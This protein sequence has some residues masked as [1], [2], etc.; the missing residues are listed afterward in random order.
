MS[1]S[2]NLVIA[3]ILII[4]T[5]FL[6]STSFAT[7]SDDNQ[8]TLPLFNNGI[9][10]DI[11]NFTYSK[12][13]DGIYNITTQT[14]T[15]YFGFGLTANNNGVPVQYITSDFNWEHSKTDIVNGFNITSK[16]SNNAW[17]TNFTFTNESTKIT[18]SITNIGPRLTDTKFYYIFSVNIGDNISYRDRNYQVKEE[19]DIHL[20]NDNLNLNTVATEI[21]KNNDFYFD[22]SDII[23]DGFNVTDIHLTN[24]SNLGLGTGKTIAMGFTKNNGIFPNGTTVI[25]DPKI[26][27]K[28]SYKSVQSNN[29][30]FSGN[31][32]SDVVF[33]IKSE[34]KSK[35][36]HMLPI[37]KSNHADDVSFRVKT[38]IFNEIPT[39]QENTYVVRQ[40]DDDGKVP[41]KS[42]ITI[43]PDSEYTEFQGGFSETVVGGITAKFTKTCTGMLNGDSC[44]FDSVNST[45]VEINIT[46]TRLNYIENAITNGNATQIKLLISNSSGTNTNTSVYFNGKTYNNFSDVVSA[47]GS[48]QQY[49]HFYNNL[50]GIIYINRTE[51]G[52]VK[53][54]YNKEGETYN[55]T[56]GGTNTYQPNGFFPFDS[57]ID[58]TN[59]FTSASQASYTVIGGELRMAEIDSTA[60]YILLKNTHNNSIFSVRVRNTH[61]NGAPYMFFHPTT[62]WTANDGM[63]YENVSPKSQV[64]VGGSNTVNDSFAQD[65]SGIY[66]FMLTIPLTGN[67]TSAIYLPTGSLS[68][69][70]TG[71]PTSRTGYLSLFEWQ[72]S[73][74][75]VDDITIRNSDTASWNTWSA[76]KNVSANFTAGTHTS[77][78]YNVTD[79]GFNETIA[80]Q[81][82][83]NVTYN[84]NGYGTAT[85]EVIVYTIDDIIQLTNET[86]NGSIFGNSTYTPA[87]YL[88]DVNITIKKPTTT[89]DNEGTSTLITNDTNATLT[90]EN[91]TQWNITS[92]AVNTSIELYYNVSKSINHNPT[93]SVSNQGFTSSQNILVVVTSS[94]TDGSSQLTCSATLD[95]TTINTCTSPIDF[96]TKSSGDYTFYW[97]GTDNNGTLS[98]TGTPFNETA[99]I[100]ITQVVISPFSLR[101]GLFALQNYTIPSNGTIL[102]NKNHSILSNSI[103]I[104]FDNITGSVWN[105][106]KNSLQYSFEIGT[107]IGIQFQFNGKYNNSEYQNNTKNNISTYLSDLT[108]DPYESTLQWIEFDL[109]NESESLSDM[110]NFSNAMAINISEVTNNKFPIYTLQELSSLDNTYIIG[111]STDAMNFIDSSTL[112][113]FLDNQSQQL[114]TSTKKSV[115]Y[116]GVAQNDTILNAISSYKTNIFNRMRGDIISGFSQP[117]EYYSVYIDNSSGGYDIILFNNQSTIQNRTLPSMTG[118]Y[119]DTTNDIIKTYANTTLGFNVSANSFIYIMNENVSKLVLNNSNA[120]DVYGQSTIYS[121]TFLYNGTEATDGIAPPDSWAFAGDNE[122]LKIELFDPTYQKSG[123]MIHYEWINA[124]RVSDYS[125]YDYVIVADKNPSE[126]SDTINSS[127]IYGYVAVSDYVNT[128]Q[129][130]SDKINETEWW[131]DRGHNLFIDGID[132][133]VGGTNFSNRFKAIVDHVRITDNKETICNTY[134]AYQEFATYCNAVMKESAFSRWDGTVNNPVYSYEDMDLEKQR[135][136]YYNS[137]NIPVILM[138]FGAID[139]YEKQDFTFKAGAVVYGYDGNNSYKYGQPN[140]QSQAEIYVSDLGTMLESSYTETSPTD[141]NRLYSKGRVHINPVNHTA[142][143]DDSKTINYIKLEAF[144]YSGTYA[145]P[146]GIQVMMQ[147]PNGSGTITD[148]YCNCSV[149]NWKWR[150]VSIPISE[151]K[152]HGHYWTYFSNRGTGQ[153]NFMAHDNTQGSGDG[154]HSYWE[155][156]ASAN[157][158]T[159]GNESNFTW[160]A[161]PRDQNWMIRLNI[162]YTSTLKID[163]INNSYITQSQSRDATG[164]TTLNL[165]TTKDYLVNIYT[166]TTRYITTT[167]SQVF[168]K[169]FGGEWTVGNIPS[170]NTT[171]INATSISWTETTVDGKTFGI[172]MNYIS[173]NNW[174]IRI[175]LPDSTSEA[176]IM[177]NV[178]PSI[179]NASNKTAIEG[180]T[181][182]IDIDGTDLNSDTLSYSINRTDLFSDFSTSTGQGNWTTTASTEG[183]YIVDAGVS[184]GIGNTNTTFTITIS[185]GIPQNLASVNN[186]DHAHLSWDAVS[187]ASHYNISSLQHFIYYNSTGATIDGLRDSQYNATAIELMVDTPNPI[188]PGSSDDFFLFYNDTHI[189]MY[190][191]GT[192]NDNIPNDDYAE[193]YL[194]L[195]ANGLTT[196]DYAYKVSE[197]SSLTRLK[198]SGSAWLTNPGSS[199]NSTATGSSTNNLTFEIEIPLSELS[200]SNNSNIKLLLERESTSLNP[201]IE[202]FHPDNNINNTDNS[203]WLN[204]TL[205]PSLSWIEVGNSTSPLFEVTSLTSDEHYT[206][207]V[208][209]TV[210]LVSSDRAT[211]EIITT[212]NPAY[213]ISGTI[214]D[215]NSNPLNNTTISISH[216]NGVSFAITTS[217]ITGYYNLQHI[218][219]STDIVTANLTG[220][221]PSSTQIT[222]NGSDTTLNFILHTQINETVLNTES[223]SLA[224]LTQSASTTITSNF[225]SVNSTIT[226]VTLNITNPNSLTTSYSMT[227]ST[228]PT[229][230]NCSRTHTTTSIVGAYT[231]NNYTITDSNSL[232][233]TIT[234]SL[235][236]EVTATST[237]PASSST[238]TSKGSHLPTPIPTTTS[239]TKTPSTKTPSEPSTPFEKF[240]TPI[241]NSLIQISDNLQDYSYTNAIPIPLNEYWKFIALLIGTTLSNLILIKPDLIKPNKV[242]ITFAVA[243]L[244]TIA[245]SFIIPTYQFFSLPTLFIVGL[246]TGFATVPGKLLINATAITVLS[247]LLITIISSAI[248]LPTEIPSLDTPS[249]TESKQSIK[250]SN[251]RVYPNLESTH[252][253]SAKVLTTEPVNMIEITFRNYPINTDISFITQVNVKA[254]PTLYS[255][256][257]LNYIIPSQSTPNFFTISNNI[258]SSLSS[259]IIGT[260]NEQ[261]IHSVTIPN[262]IQYIGVSLT[263]TSLFTETTK[264]LL[265]PTSTPTTFPSLSSI[266]SDIISNFINS[267]N[268]TQP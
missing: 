229:S 157:A 17:I 19:S 211:I 54:F 247:L 119:I 47:V 251:F 188:T 263:R 164:N 141:W 98:G 118:T 126:L 52:T 223:I 25:I 109:E 256:T 230:A 213:N 195:T 11:N 171:S 194:D 130:V 80:T 113:S 179:S 259:K 59:D 37:D 214:T 258:P 175:L 166:T 217:N 28:K 138:S 134:T 212:E 74:A 158:P 169:V 70:R 105:D 264:S 58:W 89:W 3:S 112:T 233:K 185:N 162:S 208:N 255:G 201:D 174:D 22:Y 265:T 13:Q 197:S 111:N 231:I 26:S 221:N 53:L 44:S 139:D 176:K 261:P 97:N 9:V 216:I 42:V 81:S 64:F 127:N 203:L 129:W 191:S 192:D 160:N 103:T 110:S 200:L 15:T 79:G 196:D 62:T 225:T 226:T 55:N 27:N 123:T 45:K 242:L 234:S 210:G 205:S 10:T 14:D 48:T 4:L 30:K 100:T 153:F 152:E 36:L 142:W 218:H 85:M 204:Q 193:V 159:D 182:Y 102:N 151:Y 190:L 246:A 232:T 173:L 238:S 178:L 106:F 168:Y 83:D 78:D 224:S 71:T 262:T 133:S 65:L 60:N 215:S 140:F 94:D 144:M 61:T 181:I 68:V 170:S 198:W 239:T 117:N 82:I 189:F 34:M 88:T 237:T 257:T 241:K 33:P 5:G 219:N 267:N 206:F 43:D 49:H 243:S 63:L 177:T 56:L 99:I 96:G 149:G 155:S 12:Q 222:T 187:G 41:L 8:S 163:T 209:S 249:Y 77:S 107:R 228:T 120:H 137:H 21:K 2:T 260:H 147:T 268:T 72:G 186:S 145:Q 207:G 146:N 180:Q 116:Y 184:D 23:L 115:V 235:T 143:V 240:F 16:T 266:P 67:S 148:W 90:S 244:L 165:T 199:A 101:N 183:T 220:Y 93:G 248:L 154:T 73:Y 122:D 150:N 172:V 167:I 135:A 250:D 125:S 131:S 39:L 38:T 31:I 128:Q 6:F 136:D 32:S 124:S 35:R 108:Q 202:T 84:S 91:T 254:T 7:P 46:N 24:A 50:S 20:T 161:Y 236:F 253:F 245:S 227:C 76:E 40:I 66:T 156:N 69:T 95:G 132:F 57:A 92:T 121:G 51:N 86:S 104:D 252:I 1:K 87:A 75:Y 29:P 114:R 18:N